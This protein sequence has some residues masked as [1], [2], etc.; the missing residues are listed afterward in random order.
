MP[1]MQLKMGIRPERS[2]IWVGLVQ[3]N[4]KPFFIKNLIGQKQGGLA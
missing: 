1:A 3:N 4:K 2:L